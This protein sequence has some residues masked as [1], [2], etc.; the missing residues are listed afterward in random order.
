VGPEAA[1]GLSG[2]TSAGGEHAPEYEESELPEHDRIDVERLRKLQQ[3]GEPVVVVD[4]RTDR[5]YDSSELD[6]AGAVRIVPGAGGTAPGSIIDQA[7]QLRVPRDAWIV[8]FC[9]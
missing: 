2:G 8:V 1:D 9:A 6:A 5:T 4:S 3:V 7:M